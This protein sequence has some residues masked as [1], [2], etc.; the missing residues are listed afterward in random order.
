MKHETFFRLSG[1]VTSVAFMAGCITTGTD[2]TAVTG[3]AG[4][5]ASVGASSGLERCAETLGTLAVDDGRN[6]DWIGQFGSN[7]G[8]TSIEPLLR[9]AVQQSNCFVITSI[10]NQRTDDRLSS[11]TQKQRESGEY[12][13]GSKQ[14]KG[15]RVA[16]DY[17]LEPSIIISNESTGGIGSALSGLLGAKN[18]TLGNLAGSV[19]S[20]AS[21]VTLSLFDIRA[22][23]QISA[24]E[25]SSTATN[26]GAAL[27]A[28][29]T[30]AGGT[31][32]GYT[33]TPAGK[34][35]VA[36]FVDAY[37]KMVVSLRNYKAQDVKGGLGK[38]GRLQ[39]N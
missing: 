11:I 20:K 12:R 2:S 9:L 7:T 3:S 37:N 10:G 15:Q 27:G 24:S 17:F 36:A 32:D 29:G 19:E 26:F 4:G 8:V 5:G 28:F 21:V 18:R 13:A 33:K 25:G 31:L 30:S 23:I 39:V 38:G 22:A 16:A 6:S 1:I 14:E 35:T 34:A